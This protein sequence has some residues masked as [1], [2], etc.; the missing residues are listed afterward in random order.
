MKWVVFAIALVGSVPLGLFARVEERVQKVLLALI[1][2]VP[3]IE[4]D[5]VA[6]NAYSFQRYRGESR[7]F[8]ITIVDLFA[9][10][11]FIALPRPPQFPPPYRIARYAYFAV[12]TISMFVAEMPLY[13]SFSMWK[14]LRAY[15]CMIVVAR[16]F[17][18]PRLGPWLLYGFAGGIAYSL[19]RSLE[20]RYLLGI[21]QAAGAFPHPNSMGM[22]INLVYP[23]ALAL[24]MAGQGGKTAVAM[25]TAAGVCV[26]LTLSR[27]SLMMF[28]VATAIVFMG[29]LWRGFTKRKLY[30]VGGAVLLGAGVLG[31]AADTIIERFIKAP[32]ASVE[33]RELFN[34]AAS[35]MLSDHPLGVGINNFS[36]SLSNGG[37]A[38]AL[39]LPQI[40]WGAIAHHIYWLTLAEMGYLGLVTY[41]ALHAGPLWLSL[42]HA[43]KDKRDPR[44]DIL[45]GFFAGLVVT[46]GQGFAEWVMRQTPMTYLY[47]SVAGATATLAQQVLLDREKFAAPSA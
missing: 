17:E 44:A 46:H 4:I 15:F 32:D 22:A 2:L 10:A 11:L 42:R 8:E 34:Q 39:R 12:A 33:A 7:G 26:I 21:H 20:Q 23:S 41:V 40:D 37:Y 5:R 13:S 19:L 31:Y 38:R 27:G 18:S 47:W 29:S 3:F 43:V 1:G 9:I 14:I 25:A 36:Y 6:I 35:M 16:A 30:V 24:L 28:G 45:L